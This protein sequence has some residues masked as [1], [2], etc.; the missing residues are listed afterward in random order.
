MGIGATI[1]DRG[2]IAIFSAR[3]GGY[4]VEIHGRGFAKYD[5]HARG[6]DQVCLA[7]RHYL[8][9]HPAPVLD[10]PTCEFIETEQ[11]VG[12]GIPEE[13]IGT[14]SSPRIATHHS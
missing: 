9:G 2:S 14:G 8:R 11:K 12:D 4:R 5:V 10:C 1:S 3:G 13:D 6:V 7:I